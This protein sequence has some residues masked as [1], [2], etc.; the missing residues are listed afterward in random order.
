MQP[1][2]R[3]LHAGGSCELLWRW[4]LGRRALIRRTIL[5]LTIC[6]LAT[7]AAFGTL[8]FSHTPVLHAIGL[9]VCLGC[10]CSFLLSALL[11]ERRVT[12]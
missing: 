3:R 9:T 5:S 4:R 12:S 1:R 6:S 7:L 8:A 10:I 2:D 11:A